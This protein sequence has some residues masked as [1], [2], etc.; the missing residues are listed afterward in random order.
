MS[1]VVG[2]PRGS[3]R[4]AE[5][6]A[7]EATLRALVAGIADPAIG[8]LWIDWVDGRRDPVWLPTPAGAAHEAAAAAERAAEQALEPR[9]AAS[10]MADFTAG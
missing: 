6:A 10:R 5:A 3:A 9:P 1:A 8:G 4:S 7:V 2:R